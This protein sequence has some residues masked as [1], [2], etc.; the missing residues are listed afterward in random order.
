M[1]KS[2]WEHNK[3]FRPGDLVIDVADTTWL[4]AILYLGNLADDKKQIAAAAEG[5][6]RY[7]IILDVNHVG[8]AHCYVNV[9]WSDG[10]NSISYHKDIIKANCLASFIQK[11]LREGPA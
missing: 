10:K 3:A 4:A 5:S 9:H 11:K 8:T 2:K 7:G 6:T 1:G